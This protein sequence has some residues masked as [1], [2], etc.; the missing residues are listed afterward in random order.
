MNYLQRYASNLSDAAKPLR[1]IVKQNQFVWDEETHGES[2]F[3]IKQ[4]LTCTPILLHYIYKEVTLQCEAS[5]YSLGTCLL[6]GDHPVA[7][8]S[9]VLSRTGTNYA[10]IEKKL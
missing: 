3:E 5:Q 4:A 8:A 1:D 9:R 10:H 6:Q 2:L 7:Y